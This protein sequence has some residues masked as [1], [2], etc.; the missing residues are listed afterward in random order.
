MALIT[1]FG[2]TGCLPDSLSC[3]LSLISDADSLSRARG[4]L[5]ICETSVARNLTTGFTARGC[6]NES[7]HCNPGLQLWCSQGFK[8]NHTMWG[9]KPFKLSYTLFGRQ[10]GNFHTREVSIFFNNPYDVLLCYVQ[11]QHTQKRVDTCMQR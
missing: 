4:C 3:L 11:A 2:Y 7:E 5:R 6:I 9:E 10:S 8:H 1:K